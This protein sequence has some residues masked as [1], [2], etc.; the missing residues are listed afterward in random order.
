[1]RCVYF[2]SSLAVGIEPSA[3]GVTNARIQRR[4]L[5]CRR[6]RQ[7]HLVSFFP[8]RRID[9]VWGLYDQRWCCAEIGWF[10]WYGL[11]CPTL[12]YFSRYVGLAFCYFMCV[13]YVVCIHRRVVPSQSFSVCQRFLYWLIA[14][15]FVPTPVLQR[16]TPATY[17]LYISTI[18]SREC[19]RQAETET[20]VNGLRSTVYAHSLTHRLTCCTVE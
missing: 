19:N 20:E 16:P 3:G 18:S 17:V 13:Y 10:H 6:S 2:H 5:F 8:Q 11:I 15:V 1:M 4:S 12:C 9:K 14:N 7:P